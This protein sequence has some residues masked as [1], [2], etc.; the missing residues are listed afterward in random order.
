MKALQ[1]TGHSFL[2]AFDAVEHAAA[3]D[4]SRP[5]L[6]TILLDVDDKGAR[7]VA[8]D[9]Y[10]IAVADLEVNEN[11]GVTGRFPLVRADLALARKAMPK[12]V[13]EVAFAVEEHL[14]SITVIWPGMLASVHVMDGTFPNYR[15][16]IPAGRPIVALNARYLGDL[17]RLAGNGEVPVVTMRY[18][19]PLE[20]VSFEA[21]GV[22]EVVM[23]VRTASAIAQ[24]DRLAE[25]R[26]SV[27]VAI[28]DPSEWAVRYARVAYR[29]DPDTGD[30]S[31]VKDV[32]VDPAT[33]VPA[34]LARR[35]RALVGWEPKAKEVAA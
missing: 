31:I 27:L 22:R 16:V 21:D 9:N 15:Q 17:K 3:R 32:S 5:I 23:P 25:P 29:V 12:S 8:A 10:R 19:S 35:L 24:G 28:G 13:Y 6:T 11:E 26:Q 4:E 33:R 2:R 30:V 20:P 34:A 18:T 7:L 1:V 14:A